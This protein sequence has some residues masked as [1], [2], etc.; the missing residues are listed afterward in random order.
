MTG[1]WPEVFRDYRGVMDP[2]GQAAAAIR[3]PNAPAL[4]GLGV[5]SAFPT[6]DPAAPQ[7]IQSVSQTQTIPL[8]S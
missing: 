3:I 4:I 7:G 8:G 2:K 1:Q 5:H 6:L